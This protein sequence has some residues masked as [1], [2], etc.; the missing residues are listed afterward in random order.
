[1]GKTFFKRVIILLTVAGFLLTLLPSFFNWQG[2]LSPEKTHALMLAGTV[3]WFLGAIFLFGRSG[4]S[5]ETS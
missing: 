3:L 2:L 1:M 4:K 5:T